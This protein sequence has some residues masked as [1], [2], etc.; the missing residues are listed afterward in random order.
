MA[1]G[2]LG[3]W[4]LSFVSSGEVGEQDGGYEME[5]EKEGF[6]RVELS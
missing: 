2:H 3:L 1:A 5:E 4:L 6:G